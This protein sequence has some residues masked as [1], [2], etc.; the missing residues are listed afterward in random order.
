MYDHIEI[1]TIFRGKCSVWENPFENSGER[2]QKKKRILI[3]IFPETEFSS[4][5]SESVEC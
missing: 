1:V 5:L 3:F 4:I 2:E